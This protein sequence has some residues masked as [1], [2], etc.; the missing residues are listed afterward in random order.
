VAL[1][2][3]LALALGLAGA[4][5]CGG[6]AAVSARPPSQGEERARQEARAVVDEIYRAMKGGDTDD[7]LSL[8]SDDVVVLG[9]GPAQLSRSRAEVVTALREVIDD[10]K[11][12][13][14]STQGLRLAIGPGGRSAFAV[15]RVQLAGRPAIALALLDGERSIWRVRAVHLQA[16]LGAAAIRK[17]GDALKIGRAHV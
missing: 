6:K 14:F 9:P 5:G 2:P 17:A 7:L 1:L 13:R 11:K 15:D 16:P 12:T 10:R 3:G 4:A 8:M